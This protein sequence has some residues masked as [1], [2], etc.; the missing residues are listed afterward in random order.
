[1][2]DAVERLFDGWA[3]DGGAE[4]MERE[5]GRPVRMFLGGVRLPRRFTFLDVGCG[6]GWVVRAV[7]GMEGC[8]GAV[9]IDKS[10]RMIKNARARSARRTESY[11][12]ADIEGWATRRRFDVA[13]AMESIYYA[14]SPQAALGRI[15][16]L[17]RPGG[18]FFCGT[19][20]YAENKA[21]A[22]W[23][24]RM[25][26]RMH[27]FSRRRWRRLFEEAG[28]EAKTV[29]VKDKADRKRWKR[30]AGTLFITGIKKDSLK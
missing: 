18:V 13:F 30:E 24:A 22:G 19:D 16:A 15:H 1:M 25:N 29:T 7:A 23:P 4:R 27:L 11:V 5:H 26:L 8:R 6:N 17:L 2:D 28:F 14:G 3:A 12:V 21:T 20:F 9:G 10:G